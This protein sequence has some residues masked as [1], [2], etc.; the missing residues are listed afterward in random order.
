MGDTT[1]TTEV[2]VEVAETAE[3]VPDSEVVS[4]E[5][6]DIVAEESGSI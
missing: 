6:A 1:N 2:E 3:V 4:E 5:V